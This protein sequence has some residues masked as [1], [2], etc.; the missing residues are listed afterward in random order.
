[1][2]T[3]IVKIDS[4]RIRANGTILTM[5]D[6]EITLLA[7]ILTCSQTIQHNGRITMRMAMAITGVLTLG[8]LRAS[9]FGQANS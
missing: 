6:L 1:M 4:Q 5:M 2:A 3:S 7:I 8:I 9:S